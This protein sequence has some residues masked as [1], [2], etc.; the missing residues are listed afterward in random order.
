MRKFVNDLLPGWFFEE[1]YSF[2]DLGKIWIL[3]HPSVKVVVRFK[4]LQMIISEV[5]LPEEKEWFVVSIV[6]ASNDEGQRK[7]LWVEMMNFAKSQ[8]M[9]N[10]PWIV[11]GDF[12]QVLDPLEHSKPATLNVDR[13]TREFRDCLLNADLSDLTFRGNTF[14]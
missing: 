14:T 13:R 11:L 10:K 8:F 2:S 1:N 12:N 5:L 3:W 9:A 4:S 7:D 6:Y